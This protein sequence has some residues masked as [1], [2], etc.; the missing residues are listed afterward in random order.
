MPLRIAWIG[1]VPGVR[2]TG[3]VPGVATELVHGLAALGHRVDCFIPGS[4]REL[5]E[6]LLS[7][8]RITFVWGT[9]GWRRNRWY[10]RRRIVA[11]L[12]VM[13]SRSTASIRLRREVLRRHRA[14]P[15][16]VI[17]QFSS[18]E[19]LSAPARLRRSVPLVVHPETHAAGELSWMLRE[20]RIGKSCQPLHEY[21][22]ALLTLGFRAFVQ[23]RRI[24][25]ADMLICISSVFR[26][27][28]VRDY[29]FPL[30][31]T[32]VIPNPV[33]LER[34]TALATGRATSGTVLVLGRV[35]ARKGIEDVVSVARLLRERH[36]AARLRIVG[37]PGS[38]SDYT[39]LLE[40]LPETA[41]Y[42]G[43]VG[44]AQVPDEL[45]RADVLLQASKYE[46]FG[47]T[48]G[49]ALAAGVPVVATTEVGAIEGVERS[50]SIVVDPGDVPA[51]ADAIEQTLGR[52][53]AEPAS[54]RAAAR[55]Q[56]QLLFDPARV[57]AQISTALLE[58]SA[59]HAGA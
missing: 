50:V 57:C 6:R 7:D 19:S 22:L 10:N 32:V 30:E 14:E 27:H 21:A 39:S 38:W 45:A 4:G 13:L 42:A 29:R 58:L 40:H 31:R 18:I 41:E 46:P 37:G 28:M 56:A 15:Y 33:R 24:G 36:A 52:L 8:P 17:Y 59:R 55:A 20:R 1:G 25:R 3:G 44:A 26:D 53:R 11:A 16:D 23:K 35:A 9:A 5:P 49:E 47:L 12:T 48:V 2:E 51:M 43:R 34:F 54:L